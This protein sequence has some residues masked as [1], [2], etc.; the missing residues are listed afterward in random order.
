MIFRDGETYAD[1]EYVEKISKDMY[2]HQFQNIKLAGAYV[3]NKYHIYVSYYDAYTKCLKYGKFVYRNERDQNRSVEARYATR[4]TDDGKYVVDGVDN[5]TDTTNKG[6]YSDIKIDS[7]SGIP[8]PV[9]AYY[10]KYQGDNGK[11]R[12]ARGKSTTPEGAN[13]TNW[14]YIDVNSPSGAID[15]GRFVAM[16]MDNGG[17]LHITAQD[18][19]NGILYYGFF[20]KTSSGYTISSD[21]WQKVDSTCA[22]KWND[23][24]LENPAGENSTYSMES[25]KPVITYMNKAKTDTTS[26]VKVAYY[27]DCGFDSITSPSSYAASDEKLSVVVSALDKSRVTNKY[28]VG[29]NSNE[30]AVDFLRGED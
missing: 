8:I 3:D 7:S 13:T 23:I 30:F 25:C 1:S 14:D 9:I 19:T 21:G 6:Q 4:D 12:I 17:N 24:K 27:T 28:A 5:T 15:F 18:E 26:A 22:G 2:R 11:L 10:Y 16:E 29:F 20:N